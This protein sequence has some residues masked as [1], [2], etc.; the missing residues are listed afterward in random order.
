MFTSILKRTSC[1]FTGIFAFLVL[2]G[3]PSVFGQETGFFQ[4]LYQWEPLQESDGVPRIIANASHTPTSGP[5][6]DGNLLAFVV[7]K[8]V[9]VVVDC[10]TQKV[11]REKA[12]PEQ[13]ILHGLHEGYVFYYT[14]EAVD[15]RALSLETQKEKVFPGNLV[16]V[17]EDGFL[18]TEEKG[19]LHVF[20]IETEECIF[21]E[22]V[23]GGVQ[24]VITFGN[25]IFVPTQDAQ[26]NFS[27]YLGFVPQDR[28]YFPIAHLSPGA[29][30]SFP[31]RSGYTWESRN[32]I[33]SAFLPILYQDG[34]AVFLEFLDEAGEMVQRFPLLDIVP[35][36]R[37][38]PSPLH[39]FDAFSGKML[40]AIEDET[41]TFHF[42]IADTKEPPISLGQFTPR[43]KTTLYGA[44]LDDG[45]VVIIEEKGPEET[46]LHAFSP[47]GKRIA[48]KTLWPPGL[49][50]KSCQ[51]VGGKE[52]LVT[53]G[54]LLLRYTL[55]AGELSGVFVF[56]EG[57][58]PSERVLVLR[59][60]GFTFLS[61]RFERDEGIKNPALV[62]FDIS[63]P[64]WP[65]PIELVDVSPHGESLFQVFEDLPTELRFRTLPELE[66]LLSVSVEEVSIT[67]EEER[68]TFT[69]LTPK[70]QDSTP[71][72]TMVI[73]SLGPAQRTFSM[74][75]IP[76]PNP[77]YLE[78][79][80]YPEGEYLVANWTL[81]N[82][83]LMDID[84][85]LFN[86]ETTN[87]QFVSGDPLPERI[88][89]K[90]VIH[91]KI[92]FKY[93]PSTPECQPLWNGYTFSASGTLRVTSRRGTA[94][95][96]FDASY[97]VHPEYAFEI[98]IQRDPERPWSYL[99]ADDILR[100][101]QVF[102]ATGN[103]ITGNL[104]LEKRDD[105]VVRIQGVAPGFPSVPLPLHL[106][107]EQGW[108]VFEF[109]ARL[110]SPKE[111][112]IAPP[113]RG[114]WDISLAFPENT[115]QQIRESW[116]F[117]PPRFT[118]T[119][120]PNTHPVADFFIS[121]DEIHY[122]R[123]VAFD[124]SASSD[125][126]GVIIKYEWSWPG[127]T[128][129][130][131]REFASAF[132]TPQVIPVTLRVTDDRFQEASITKEVAVDQERAIGGR[133]LTIPPA[134]ARQNAATYQVEVVT[135]D[136]EN[137]GTDAQVFLALYESKEREGVRCGS[138]VMRLF[139]D[140][141][142]FER[143]QR[144]TFSVTGREIKDLDHIVLLHDN[145]GNK[146]GWFV[147]GLTVRD[148][149]RGKEWVF[150]PNRWLALDT[151]DRKTYG[152]FTPVTNLYP[153]GIFAEGER[154]SFNLIEA[155]DTVSILPTTCSHFYFTCLDG[156][157]DMEVFRQDGRFLGRQPANPS[158]GKREPP[159]LPES[160][161]GVVF[162]AVNLTRPERFLIRTQKGGERR[163]KTIW[164]FPS[165][166]AN[167]KKEALQAVVLS[168]LKGKTEVFL[169]G[170]TVREYLAGLQT[171][172][173][174][175][176][177]PVIDYGVN[178]FSI[179]GVSPDDYLTDALSEG[180]EDYLENQESLIQ[181]LGFT[182][183]LA[184]STVELL[185]YLYDALNWSFKL[186]GVVSSSIAQVYK[187]VLLHELG[188]SDPTLWQIALLLE[189]SKILVEEIIGCLESNNPASCAEKLSILKT[190]TVGNRPLSPTLSDHTINYGALG[191]ITDCEPGRPDY[192]LAILLSI[193]TSS[194]KYWRK[195]GH[196]IYR[197]DP[198]LNILSHDP[199]TDTNAA[200]DVYEPLLQTIIQ[201]GSI[202]INVCLLS[203]T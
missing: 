73:A 64:G 130:E 140:G 21:S 75:V 178:A 15:T 78:V 161:W 46:V 58:D 133:R 160:E 200:L 193:A 29:R 43:G 70:L 87:L 32:S 117:T 38:A 194:V 121:E 128:P 52:L 149:R 92:F 168:A 9:L 80:T 156:Q 24:P 91:G 17:A 56:P 16:L 190:I 101:L 144:D 61:N 145:S 182:L 157:R 164:V 28:K 26:R 50:A 169:C 197:D 165:N 185:S 123:N 184:S 122:F 22:P 153:A 177:L 18:V 81:R 42:F 202:L 36:P 6:Q 83:A 63:G 53:Q 150:L 141:N 148:T 104:T 152:K 110:G 79:Q 195:N 13:C 105:Y 118:L 183:E 172:F 171:N 126:D 139:H 199:V 162:E 134:F 143:G 95:A 125:P 115:V 5:F 146:P 108:R 7:R 90:E 59:D 25:V 20:D 189:R 163:E 113:L 109:Q 111:R 102:D 82:N 187:V 71:K 76:F 23:P 116:R 3:F 54:H 66:K 67:K 35:A 154:K 159:Y 155:S 97:A 37:I 138:G 131:A 12:F 98:Q 124:G 34:D 192:P 142:P 57:Y 1:L 112:V 175:A 68:F 60:Q 55:P 191:V 196:S 14:G 173:V 103:N 201:T 147:V 176:S 96:S 86:L 136:R 84:D 129:I 31:E 106:T 158:W 39:F 62:A 180:V 137:A 174:N 188:E 45:T 27:G 51:V 65:F 166:W 100:H 88:A 119:L 10:A 94:E 69:W 77:L 2:L 127:S 30:F 114:S 186:P 40:L 49:S 107:W 85:L 151:G 198:Y 99:F 170:K 89:E 179:F 93:L 74:T 41:E 33:P 8:N 11:I 167:Y 44:F 181:Q 120:P 47:D 135:G 72:V 4:I 203:G 19:I 132:S 48:E